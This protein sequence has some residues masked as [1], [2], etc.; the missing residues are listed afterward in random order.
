[1]PP[2]PMPDIP[3]GKLHDLIQ[4]LH[5]LHRRSGWPSLREMAKGQ[6]FSYAAVHDLF[7]KTSTRAPQPDV[8]LAVVASLASRVRKLDVEATLD[9]FDELW[10][11]ASASPFVNTPA[12]TNIRS[13]LTAQELEVL[14]LVGEGWTYVAVAR[15]MHF[16][17]QRLRSCLAAI[18]SKLD[19]PAHPVG[20]VSGSRGRDR[21]AKF[22]REFGLV[23]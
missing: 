1:M 2:L 19:S 7:T 3:P 13:R 9:Q 20:S 23:D 10:S 4:E 21:L 12:T 16:G 22:A 6:R 11:A 18:R 14:R 17:D 8:V 15:H 5:D